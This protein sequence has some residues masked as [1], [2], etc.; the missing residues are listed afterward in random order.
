MSSSW[1]KFW[2]AL[3]NSA[4]VTV[5]LQQGANPLKAEELAMVVLRFRNAIRHQQESVTGMELEVHYRELSTGHHAQRQGPFHGQLH[6][7][8]VRWQMTGVGQPAAPVPAMRNTR[9]VACAWPRPQSLW[10]NS[11][12]TASGSGS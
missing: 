4:A 6:S 5:L 8:Q 12:N 7:V 2:A 11:C 3:A 1:P 9:Q 10:F